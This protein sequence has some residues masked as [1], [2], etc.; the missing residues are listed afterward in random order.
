MTLYCWTQLASRDNHYLPWAYP[1]SPPAQRLPQ[2]TPEKAVGLTAIRR[3]PLP[4]HVGSRRPEEA[5]MEGQWAKS[6][7]T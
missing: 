1:R 2:D 4:V 3:M 6:L 5:A 7:L